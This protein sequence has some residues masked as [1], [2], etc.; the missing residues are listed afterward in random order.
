MVDASAGG[1][2]VESC[3]EDVNSW[4]G[5]EEGKGAPDLPLTNFNDLSDT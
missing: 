4:I 2:I 3:G 1:R 5:S